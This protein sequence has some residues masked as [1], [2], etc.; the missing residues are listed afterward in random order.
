MSV[1]THYVV[2]LRN[3][4]FRRDRRSEPQSAPRI[5]VDRD[6]LDD[7]SHPRKAV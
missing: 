1:P 2:V 4:V 5:G 7:S 3:S 6:F